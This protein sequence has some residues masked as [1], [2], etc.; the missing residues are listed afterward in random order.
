MWRKDCYNFLRT[1]KTSIMECGNLIGYYSEHRQWLV[2]YPDSAKNYRLGIQEM[3]A[4]CTWLC[5][6]AQHTKHRQ[7]LFSLPISLHIFLTTTH[8]GYSLSSSSSR[9]LHVHIYY[10]CVTLTIIASLWSSRR[11]LRRHWSPLIYLLDLSTP[12]LPRNSLS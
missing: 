5:F 1:S 8:N 6:R 10:R 9:S 3:Y 7:H 11:Y 2:N 12:P 4:R